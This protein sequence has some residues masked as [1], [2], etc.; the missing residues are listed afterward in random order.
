MSMVG[1]LKFFLGL[2]VAQ[3]KDGTRIHQQKYLRE[4]LAKFGMKDS[5]IMAT[6][7]SP[8]DSLGKDESSPK[9]DQTLYRGMIGSLLYL[10]ASRPDIMYSVCLCAHFQADPKET[11]LKALKRI[12]LYLKGTDTL[13][14][15]YPQNADLHLVGYTDADFSRDRTDRKSSS[16][17]A[18]FMGS[19]LVSWASMKQ[20]SVTLST[21]EAEYIAATACC[22]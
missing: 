12:L 10:I 8:K 11:H 3:E 16:G 17:M 14:L 1:E 5:S 4:M 22:S 13:C 20:N 6:P 15:W 2:Q 7:I 21:A 19:C 18:Q 9:V